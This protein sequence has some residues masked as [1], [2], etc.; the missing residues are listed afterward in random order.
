MIPSALKCVPLVVE[1][2]SAWGRTA[3]Q[4]FSKLVVLL[5]A[6][7][8]STQAT[9]LNSI[10][11]RLSQILVQANARPFIARSNTVATIVDLLEG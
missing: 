7:A 10:Y 11:G 1:T 2:F 5:V 8:N 6:Q 3:G 9:M 4:F